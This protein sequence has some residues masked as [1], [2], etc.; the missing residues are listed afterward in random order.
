MTSVNEAYFELAETWRLKGSESFARLAE[1]WMTPEEA[2]VLS[3]LNWWMTT[4]ELAK[5]L[6]MDEESVKT[7][8]GRVGRTGLVRWKDGYWNASPNMGSPFP[9]MTPP[10]VPEEQF[11]E[12]WIDF[13]RSGDNQ[14][15]IVEWQIQK[16]AETGSPRHRI[17]PA[18]KALRASPNLKKDQILWYEDMDQILENTT[19]I[20]GGT[21]KD[22]CGCRRTWGTCDAPVGCMGWSYDDKPPRWTAGREEDAQRRQERMKRKISRERALELIDMAEEWGQV[23]IPANISG[24]TVTCFCCPCCCHCISPSLNYGKPYKHYNKVQVGTAPSRFLAIINQELC[25]GCQTCLTR[26]HFSAIE[27]VKIPGS[28]KLKAS[29]LPEECM[30]CG[31]C[32]F[33]C[34][35]KAIRFE[36]VRPPSHIPVATWNDLVNQPV[37]LAPKLEPVK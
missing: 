19:F 28:K 3:R 32:V 20:Q 12:R 34:P 27:M 24:D 25:N 23:N 35:Q 33:K 9:Q 29:I 36:I 10:G 4:G 14:K 26:C 13:F 30:G 11:N 15:W 21:G 31:L 18:R 2:K 1:L 7:A 37:E 17:I 6:K 22:A 8:L 5:K 16:L